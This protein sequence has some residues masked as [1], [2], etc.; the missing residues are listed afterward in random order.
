M[1]TIFGQD[2]VK[3]RKEYKDLQKL[4]GTNICSYNKLTGCKD[5]HY[6]KENHNVPKGETKMECVEI[7]CS[8]TRGGKFCR[9]YL[10]GIGCEI[11]YVKVQRKIIIKF[12]LNTVTE[13][14][15]KV[16]RRTR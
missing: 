6:I 10:V 4:R 12:V 15:G 16:E 2:N 13:L 1:S 9:R 8:T 5:V 7:I 14:V 3:N 11:G